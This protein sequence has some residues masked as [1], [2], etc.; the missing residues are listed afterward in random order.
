M[1]TN[2]GQYQSY[3]L[4]RSKWPG[5]AAVKHAQQNHPPEPSRPYRAGL[6]SRG[7]L[8]TT[9]AWEAGSFLFSFPWP[10]TLSPCS[11][12]QP[13]LSSQKIRIENAW[14]ILKRNPIMLGAVPLEY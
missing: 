6:S 8:Y 3:E 14:R 1:P 2:A 13:S 9:S 4:R 12:G 5:L 7:E 10:L 11:P